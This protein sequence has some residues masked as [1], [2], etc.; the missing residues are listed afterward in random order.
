M[1]ILYQLGLILNIRTP[2]ITTCMRWDSRASIH[3]IKWCWFIFQS[4]AP[5]YCTYFLITL[6]REL[7]LDKTIPTISLPLKFCKLTFEGKHGGTL[8][9]YLLQDLKVSSSCLDKDQKCNEL[10]MIRTFDIHHIVCVHL[11]LKTL[12]VINLVFKVTLILNLP[13]VEK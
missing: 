12:P 8:I 7:F 13:V 6:S 11:C 1:F 9:C 5:F 3:E 4:L 2:H 10:E